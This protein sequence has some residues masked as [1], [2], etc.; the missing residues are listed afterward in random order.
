[1]EYTIVS[2][3]KGSEN[4]AERVR[5]QIFDRWGQ[6]EASNYDPKCNCL[7]FNQWLENG[8]RVKKGEKAIKSI[9]MIEKKNEKGEVIQKFAKTVN[10]FYLRQVEKIS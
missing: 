3:W 8:Y 9:T 1:M 6:D 5:K 2:N 10:L 4:T 7:T